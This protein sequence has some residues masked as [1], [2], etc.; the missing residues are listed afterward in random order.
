MKIPIA[1]A[2]EIREQLDA[3]HL[4]IY[5][6]GDDGK[7]CVATH[8]KT[9]KDAERSAEMGNELKKSL[10]WPDEFYKS[11]PVERICENCVYWK[12]DW[13][14]HC[15]NGW[16]GDG[17]EGHCHLEPVRIG[18]RKDDFCRHFESNN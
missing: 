3:T 5:A 15:F 10:G 6:I 18:K 9:R 8:G 7:A 16:S 13:G 1:K 14:I 12:A 4:V 11:K 2:K 17:S